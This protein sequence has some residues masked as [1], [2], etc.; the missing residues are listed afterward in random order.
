MLLIGLCSACTASGNVTPG[1]LTDGESNTTGSVT[2]ALTQPREVSGQRELPVECAN[3][4][5]YRAQASGSIEQTEF[6]FSVTAR[7]YT[8][9]GSYPVLLTIRANGGSE[10][11]GAGG[12]IPATAQ[13]TD[14]GGRVSFSGAAASGSLEWTCS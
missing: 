12:G 6:F 10:A 3:T 5:R 7:N 11:A 4:R 1:A 13:L 9:P 2:L 8:D 14:A